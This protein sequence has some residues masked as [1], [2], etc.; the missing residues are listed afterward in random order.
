VA[1]LRARR[2]ADRAARALDAV[3]RAARGPENLMPRLVDAV[4][5]SVTL[6]EICERLRA[7]FGVHQPSVTF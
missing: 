3:E 6:G 7:V 4:D 5:A 1:H 2:D